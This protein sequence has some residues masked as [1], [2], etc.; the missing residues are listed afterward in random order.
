MLSQLEIPWLSRLVCILLELLIKAIA[1][2]PN[3]HVKKRFFNNVYCRPT[4]TAER[5]VEQ[6]DGTKI[7]TRIQVFSLL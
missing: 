2:S 7:T 4:M 5:V 3:K 6:P 1:L